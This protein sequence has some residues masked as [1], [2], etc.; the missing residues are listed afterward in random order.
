MKPTTLKVVA[1][2]ELEAEGRAALEQL[3]R[4]GAAAE[5]V[6]GGHEGG[7]SQ[8]IAEAI[9]EGKADI[10]LSSRGPLAGTVEPVAVLARG[11][12]RD[13]IVGPGHG[14]STLARLPDGSRI[15]LS[16]RRRLGLLRAHRPHLRSVGLTNGYTPGSAL[17]SGTVDALILG[18]SESRHLG[19]AERITE[20]LNPGS[21]LPAPGQGAVLVLARAGDESSRTAAA[22][23]SDLFSYLAWRCE[24][25]LVRAL[26]AGP[27][28]PLGA[29]AT[30]FGRWIRL[31]A[32]VTS[33]DGSRIVRG[34]LTGSIDDPAGL[35]EA[36][37][38]LLSRRGAGHI[39]AGDER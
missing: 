21:W 16:G 20:I 36:M 28:A 3:R 37:A 17:A 24:T 39:L 7:P 29:L 8:P 26:G 27:D 10:G 22:G 15:G 13:V 12:A 32:M 23:L 30:P 6:S 5:L 33:A 31:S 19:L 38:R 2:P 35:S 34:D 11:E 9:L 1:P 14:E 4:A 18:A 25:G